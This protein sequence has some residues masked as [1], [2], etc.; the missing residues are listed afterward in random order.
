MLPFETVYLGH[1]NESQVILKLAGVAQ[2]ISTITRMT[3]SFGSA[4]VRSTNQDSDPIKWD[5]NGYETGEVRIKLGEQSI[6][7]GKYNAPLIVYDETNTNGI[8]WGTI[9]FIVIAEVEAQ[10][11]ET[12]ESTGVTEAEVTEVQA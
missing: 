5:K 12:L 11:I 3:L 7:P 10:M 4:L 6:S 8:V 9:R 1:D 2:D